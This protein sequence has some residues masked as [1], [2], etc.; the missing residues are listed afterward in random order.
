MKK[1]RLMIDTNAYS[2]LMS[3]HEGVIAALNNALEV[4]VPITVLGELHDG[5]RGGR[6][7]AENLKTL[8]SFLAKPSV[9]VVDAT[10]VTAEHYGEIK[11]TLSKIGRPVPTNDL[12]IAAQALD[13]DAEILTFDHHFSFME[14]CGVK[15]MVYET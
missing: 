8:K 1:R 13:R 4:L 11:S 10:Q 9:K 2:A 5:F 15:V 14:P 6:R 12:W 7:V 3:G